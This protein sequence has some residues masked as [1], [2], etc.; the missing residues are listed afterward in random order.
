MT[1]LIDINIPA[2][3]ADL[4]SL[5]MRQNWMV[6]AAEISQLQAAIGGGGASGAV[7]ASSVTI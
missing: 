1:S 4:L 7:T 5:P 2:T 6:A 3:N